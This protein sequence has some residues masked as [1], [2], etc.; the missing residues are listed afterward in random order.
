MSRPT[1]WRKM[2]F[3]IAHLQAKEQPCDVEHP[4]AT[5]VCIM[6]GKELARGKQK[7]DS[8]KSIREVKE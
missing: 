6:L 4:F 3:N 8:T 7:D 2:G 1:W 5:R